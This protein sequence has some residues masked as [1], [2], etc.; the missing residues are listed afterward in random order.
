M[1]Q[2]SIAEI[3]TLAGLLEELDYYQVLELVPDAPTSAIRAAYHRTSRR[4]HPDAHRDAPPELQQQVAQVA[5]RITEAY[6][7]L[8]DPRRRQVYDRQLAGDRD[9]VRMPL[10]EAE[11]QADRQRRDQHEG[12]T[13]NGRRYFALAKADLNRGDRASAERN[14]KTALTFEP[15]NAVFR[16]L[17]QELVARPSGAAARE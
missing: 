10:A 14:L 3:R 2:T 9:R 1:S 11:A 16:A 6:A 4:F 7:V 17:L 5:K 13:P 15:D 8:R 12:R